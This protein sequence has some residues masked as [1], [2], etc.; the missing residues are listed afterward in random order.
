MRCF[1]IRDDYQEMKTTKD[2]DNVGIVPYNS[3]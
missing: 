1:K 3:L 2:V